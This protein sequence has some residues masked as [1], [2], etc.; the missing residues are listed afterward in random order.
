M[1]NRLCFKPS[2]NKIFLIYLEGVI[3]ILPIPMI[4]LLP[5][6][7]KV[8]IPPS[9]ASSVMNWDSSPDMYLEHPLSR[10]YFWFIPWDAR[11]TYIQKLNFDFRYPSFLGSFLV[12]HNSFFWNPYFFYIKIFRFVREICIGFVSYFNIFKASYIWKLVDDE[13]TKIFFRN[14]C[15]F[16]GLYSRSILS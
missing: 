13:F 3:P 4:F 1:L 6:S 2:T 14:F 9:F 5:L 7:P 16:K 10:Y 8:T 15:F 11:H 12:S